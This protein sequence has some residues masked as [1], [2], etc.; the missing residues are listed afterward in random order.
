MVVPTAPI[1]ITEVRPPS[2]EKVA[3]VTPSPQGL[4]MEFIWTENRK[5]NYTVEIMI[6]KH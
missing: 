6:N 2:E 3:Q 4:E 5:H 1:K